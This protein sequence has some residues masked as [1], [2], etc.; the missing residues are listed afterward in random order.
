MARVRTTINF[1]LQRILKNSHL[2]V[3]RSTI[4]FEELPT[5]RT[6]GT[7]NRLH[8]S[9]R[10]HLI[11]QLCVLY[12][13]LPDRISNFGNVCGGNSPRPRQVEEVGQKK[14]EGLEFRPLWHLYAELY[15]CKPRMFGYVSMPHFVICIRT[16]EIMNI[17]PQI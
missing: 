13:R 11:C 14:L 6:Q 10:M 17:N 1:F 2:R 15:F 7:T 5:K 16:I 3:R 4:L 9:T 12:G 8:S